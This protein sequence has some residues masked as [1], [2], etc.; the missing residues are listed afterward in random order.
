VSPIEST[1]LPG[2]DILTDGLYRGDNVVWRVDD[3]ADYRLFCHALAREA[4]S[5]ERAV[6]AAEVIGAEEPHGTAKSGRPGPAL[7]Y[8]R[9]AQHAPLFPEGWT[10]GTGPTGSG[11]GRPTDPTRSPA[12]G[13]AIDV[14]ELPLDRGFEL[15]ITTVHREVVSRGENA[16]LFFD[17]LS[18]LSQR[19]YSDRMI[20]NFFQLTCPLILR[21]GSVAYFSL[22][23]FFHSYHTVQ[24]ITDTTQ[25]LM[26]VFRHDEAVYVQPVK[27]DGRDQTPTF[28]L[29]RWVSDDRFEAVTA[30]AEIVP[31]LNTRPWPGLR[32]ASYRMI[33][34]WDRAFLDAEARLREVEAGRAPRALAA[35]HKD[36][37]LRLIISREERILELARLNLSLADV[38]GVWKRMVG[39]GHIGGKSV[40][41]LLANAIL[42]R[43]GGRWK[44]VLERHDSFFVG[45]DVYYTYL[46][47]NDCWWDRQRQK[48]P[49]HALGDNA[50]V[51]RRMRSGRFP[52][53]IL[54]RF[55]DMIDYFGTSPII[56]RSSS[57]LEDA[58]GN[59]FA[60]KYESVFCTMQ[61]TPAER[62]A[63]FLEA[64]RVIY[65]STISDEALA[66]RKKRGILDQDEQMALLVQR[67]S[68]DHHRS[69]APGGRWFFPHLGGVA[70]SYNPWAWHRSIDPRAGLARIVFGLG[71][72]AVDRADDDYTRV[73][74]LNAPDRRPDASPTDIRLHSQRRI[75]L[76]DLDEERLR[77][78]YFVDLLKERIPLPLTLLAERDREL[79]ARHDVDRRLAWTLTFD[80]LLSRT[81]FVSDLREM[82]VQLREVYGS[83]VDVEFTVNI[84]DG[85]EH[86]GN[87]TGTH[88]PYRINVVQ[89]RPLQVYGDESDTV[90][91][92]DISPEE[93][94]LTC[95]TVIGHS[96]RLTVSR[97]I[98]VRPAAFATLSEQERY[99]L[100]AALRAITTSAIGSSPEGVTVLIGPGR[101][102]TSTPALGVPVQVSDIGRASVLVELDR[103]HDSLITDLSLGTHFFNEMVE[104]DLLYLACREGQSSDRFAQELVEGLPNVLAE[105]PSS[106]SIPDEGG[107]GAGSPPLGGWASVIHVV[108]LDAKPWTLVASSTDQRAIIGTAGE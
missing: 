51:R 45:S 100:A 99:G 68:G 96:R 41:M 39:T 102:G 50:A 79:A 32:S 87:D 43:A 28:T 3:L 91:L 19:Y 46:V 83:E 98:L 9:F 44:D 55:S 104:E 69:E 26:D 20:G 92:P 21:T 59:A 5:A 90:V 97:V 94:V 67:V 36:E 95:G 30:S 57:L 49:D 78:V 60:G 42:A 8:F 47:I 2:L 7:V 93:T 77:S 52:A 66:Y 58:F 107:S 6:T 75:D 38:V 89:C 33:G 61:G 48:D 85:L 76:L 12:R 103:I 73:V 106:G 23:R 10:G 17:S 71:T 34:V 27:L 82:L 1:G 4:H 25:I 15:F 24:P 22:E 54:D 101:W 72:R 14:V 86:E 37:L 65:A 35:E 16:V 13:P 81:A 29:F 74:A 62:L 105:L 80:R 18:D 84:P 108:D 53:Y 63:E 70:F 11:R 88:R 40:G 31:V 56:V 64:V